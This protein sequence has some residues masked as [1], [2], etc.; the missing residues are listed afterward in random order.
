MRSVVDDLCEELARSRAQR[1][2]DQPRDQYV[3][4]ERVDILVAYA[5]HP[6][7]QHRGGLV[8]QSRAVFLVGEPRTHPR[9]YARVT[10]AL[11]YSPLDEEVRADELLQAL[12]QGVLAVGNQRG[13]RNGNAERMTKQCGHRE[14]VGHRADHGRLRCRVDEPPD[15][16]VIDRERVTT[17][18]RSNSETATARIRRKAR[19]RASSPIEASSSD[20]TA[21]RER[22]RTWLIRGSSVR[23]PTTAEPIRRG[24]PLECAHAESYAHPGRNLDRDGTQPRPV[25]GVCGGQPDRQTDRGAAEGP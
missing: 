25:R 11:A 21:G 18:A 2:R 1:F 22:S 10:D 16:V 9:G 17:A 19:R 23:H 12:G 15:T 4:D 5:P 8:D 14:P 3:A 24:R 7:T 13:V 20:G 6:G